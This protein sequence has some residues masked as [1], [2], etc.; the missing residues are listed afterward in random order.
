MSI[1]LIAVTSTRCLARQR[2]DA[3][4]A[5]VR[6]R[7][8]VLPDPLDVERVL[9]DDERRDGLQDRVDGAQ[10]FGALEEERPV[11]FADPHDARCRS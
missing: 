8:Q 7:E 3:A 1:A 2:R 10:S 5:P 11:R 9:P 4:H 6:E